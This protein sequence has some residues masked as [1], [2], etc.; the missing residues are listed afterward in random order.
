MQ[1]L[2]KLAVGLTGLTTSEAVTH[3]Q[4]PEGTDF[5][6]IIKILVQVVIGVATL[7]GLFKK[8]TPPLK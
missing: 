4:P 3:I 6:E 8:K 5:S 1:T 7:I 2:H